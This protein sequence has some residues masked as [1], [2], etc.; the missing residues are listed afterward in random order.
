MFYVHLNTSHLP[1]I[2]AHTAAFKNAF[3]KIFRSFNSSFSCT[4][5]IFHYLMP[6]SW[7]QEIH[8][9]LELIAIKSCKSVVSV[10]KAWHRYILELIICLGQYSLVQ[11]SLQL[12]SC[13]C[14]LWYTNIYHLWS[15]LQGFCKVY[16]SKMICT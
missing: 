2:H 4:K 16:D 6:L 10:L 9:N 12:Y 11:Q 3:F 15:G 14:A 7:F 1:H 8:C 13:T 5:L